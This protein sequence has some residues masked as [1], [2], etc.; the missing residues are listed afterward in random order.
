MLSPGE[1]GAGAAPH[2]LRVVV[3][4]P[5]HA[6]LDTTLSYISQRP[7][8]AG[9][10]L[11]VPLGRRIVAGVVW[12]GSS[13]PAPVVAELRAVAETVDA[14][15][16]LSAHW[17]A[18]VAFAAG[19]Y[20]RSVGE[21]ALSV[22]PPELRRLGADAVADR[23]RRLRRRLD[24]AKLASGPGRQAPH[25]DALPT[26]SAAQGVAVAAA[27]SALASAEPG[28]LLLHGV[29][30]SGKTEVYLRAAQAALDSGRQVLVLVPEINLT[31][32]LVARF[33]G[34]FAGRHIVALHS[35]LT[36]A[37]RLASWLAAHEGLADL[38]LG[39]RLAVFASLP[40]LGLVVVDEEHD[41]SYK[42]QEGARY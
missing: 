26:L 31:P 41:A 30:G 9:T 1:A 35:G 20:Q 38:V 18:L 39:T 22:L 19:Y 13:E 2:T 32:Q 3:E 6:A 16:P 15:V 5:R 10:L 17:R 24:A 33:T 28:T 12:D 34:R 8:S 25:G 11:R 42:Q 36:P 7:L 37:P 14:L 4:T 23:L 40:R 21:I 29:T 27:C